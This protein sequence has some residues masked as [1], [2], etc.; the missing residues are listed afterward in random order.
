MSGAP[1]QKLYIQDVTLRDGMHSI[2]HQYKLAD[3]LAIAKALD[4]A[5]VDAI[6]ITHQ[7]K[8]AL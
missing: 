1:Q 5:K 8:F 2:G 7:R 4:D 6:E 3:V